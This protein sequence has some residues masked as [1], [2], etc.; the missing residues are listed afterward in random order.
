MCCCRRC[1]GLRFIFRSRLLHRSPVLW[2]RRKVRPPERTAAAQQRLAS[3]R[4]GVDATAGPINEASLHQMEDRPVC[5]VKDTPAKATR[6]KFGH[7]YIGQGELFLQIGQAGL[8]V[9]SRSGEQPKNGKQHFSHRGYRHGISSYSDCPNIQKN[10]YH[11]PTAHIVTLA[12]STPYP[13]RPPWIL[14]PSSPPPPPP[15]P[16]APSPR[17]APRPARPPCTSPRARPGR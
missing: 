6:Y 13:A 10:G 3:G 14:T 12:K 17:S 8:G 15:G 5:P 9:M 11:H 16:P 1:L 2:H 7:F 4:G